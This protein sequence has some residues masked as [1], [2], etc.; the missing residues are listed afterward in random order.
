MTSFNSA[1]SLAK[2]VPKLFLNVGYLTSC[3]PILKTLKKYKL[4]AFCDLYYAALI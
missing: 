1:Q 3:V 4:M 2:V